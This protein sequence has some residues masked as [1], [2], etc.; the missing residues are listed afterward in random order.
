MAVLNRATFAVTD[1]PIGMAGQT[2][3]NLITL[4]ATGAGWGW[5]VDATPTDQAEFQATTQANVF[6]AAADSAAANKLDLLTVFIHELGHVAGL[7]HTATNGDVM[8]QYLSPGERRL[9]DAAD[10]AVLQVSGTP[11]ISGTSSTWITLPTGAA[12]SNA[13]STALQK[14]LS[15][16][17]PTL[18]NGSFIHGTVNWETTGQVAV[19]N[20][21]AVLTEATAS[22]T[23]LNQAFIVSANDRY[24]S[25]TLSGIALDDPSANSG[26]VNGPDDT[27][28][29]ALLN[30]NTGASLLS[31]LSLT[32]TDALLNLQANG[33]ELLAQGVTHVVNADG[34]RT[35]VIDL[36][37]IA[38]GT[39]VNLSFDLIGFGLGA[40]ATT[41]HVT[42]KDIKLSGALAQPTAQDDSASTLEDTG[43]TVAVLANDSLGNQAGFV[44]V[45]LAAASHGQVVLNSDGRF[46]YTPDANYFG[47]DSFT[48]Q[49]R[50]GDLTSNVAT[51]NLTVTAVNDAPV[52]AALVVNT[53]EDTA[54][55]VDL[56]AAASDVDSTALSVV[57]VSQPLHGSL[58]Q[59]AD[60]RFVY[61]PDS[62]YAGLDSFSY[63]ISDGSLNSD[64]VTVALT[65]T[66][67]NDAPI[68]NPLALSTSENTT[69]VVDLVGNSQDVEGDALVTIIVSQPLHGSVVSHPDGTVTYQADTNYVGSDSFSYRVND[70]QL[71]S[72]VAVVK[73]DVLAVNHAPV[74]QDANLNAVEDTPLIF[75][76]LSLASDADHTSLTAVILTPPAHGILAKNTDGTFTYT[77]DAKARR[78][79]KHKML[80]TKGGVSLGYTRVNATDYCRI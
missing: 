40:A 48:Y 41:S 5:Y 7:L 66:A 15:T 70:G 58:V 27:F 6:T 50:N 31:P 76:L 34:S 69:L 35:Y 25:F 55:L 77:A 49:L 43:V 23:R 59:Q 47:T 73:L 60:G 19:A 61:T 21:A 11:S 44:P 39:A 38:A 37:G 53:T 63:Q 16:I 24:L 12:L 2:T 65:V 28:E 17:N 45:L 33:T 10:M 78:C 14:A 62:N 68:A 29:V 46:S 32:R 51:V 3:A 36:A 75:D 13:I 74:A 79:A 71:D 54:V 20:N 18:T 26:Q 80:P 57:I 42:V 4:D 56:L 67:V 30:A 1:L 64:V 9:P 22:Q 72:N 8:S 52:A